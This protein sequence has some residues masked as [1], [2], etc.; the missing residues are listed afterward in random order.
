MNNKFSTKKFAF[1]LFVVTITCF[2]L[3]G[4][5]FFQSGGYNK[6]ISDNNNEKIDE[7][8]TYKAEGIKQ[9]NI[10]CDSSDVHIVPVDSTEITA[11][12]S[13]STTSNNNVEKLDAKIQDGQVIISVKKPFFFGINL[14]FFSSLK[15]EVKVPKNYSSDII[16]N[17][18]S[19]NTKIENLNLNTLNCKL[20]SGDLSTDS[21]TTKDCVLKLSSGNTRLENFSGN[22][23]VHASSGDVSVNYKEFNNNI[24]VSASSG[25]LKLK[26]PESSE[27]YL[28]ASASSGNVNCGFPMT[29]SKNQSHNK[30]EGTVVKDTNQIIIKTF[31]GDVDII[32]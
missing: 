12:L 31:S 32:K 2:L 16:I 4:F 24:D 5:I 22:L 17:T 3:S 27:F 29:I 28:K 11:H 20:S 21:V 13:G 8:K 1:W 6:I 30:L 25:N 19:G 9:I 23:K 10:A 14:N 15:L 26:L 7:S 18:S